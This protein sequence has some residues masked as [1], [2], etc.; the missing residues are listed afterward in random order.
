[1]PNSHPMLLRRQFTDSG[2]RRSG[3]GVPAAHRYRAAIRLK[4]TEKTHTRCFRWVPLGG[5]LFLT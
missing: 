4:R 2:V 1:M 5:V 3:T